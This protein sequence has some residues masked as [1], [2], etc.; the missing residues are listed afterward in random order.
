MK[1]LN[2]KK[3]T[4]SALTIAMGAGLAGAISGTFAWYQYSTRSTVAMIGTSVG[5]QGN[6]QVKA[7]RGTT[8]LI[9]FR[10][11][12]K[13]ADGLAGNCAPVTSG[14]AEKDANVA[15]FYKNP[16][17][18]DFAY[19]S[20]RAAVAETDYITFHLDF[21]VSKVVDGAAAAI[22]APSSLFLEKVTI[23]GA[24]TEVNPTID[25]V[26]DMSSAVRVLLSS[27]SSYALI[28]QDGSTTVTNG[29]LDLNG[30]HVADGNEVFT[31][32]EAA[33]PQVYG[34]G[35]QESYAQNSSDIIATQTDGVWAGGFAIT[36]SAG[37]DV[38]IWLEGWQELETEN[39]STDQREACIWS[40][41]WM[42]QQFNVG[43]AFA[44]N[45]L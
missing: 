2:F 16:H 8:T 15:H 1:T 44:T 25:T 7:R 33:D 43:L 27:G 26:K 30:D 42:G 18:K 40:S 34:E 4:V 39:D 29:Y 45:E 41:D 6:L 37:V 32:W 11:D 38:T 13:L 3:L 17:F 5:T 22:S 19:S 12:I 28:S 36:P 31:D 23:R 21:Q 10:N 35:E 24:G 14:A 20:W 9:D